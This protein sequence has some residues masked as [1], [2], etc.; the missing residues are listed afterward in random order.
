MNRLFTFCLL[1][2]FILCLTTPAWAAPDIAKPTNLIAYQESLVPEGQTVNSVLLIGKDGIIAGTVKDEVI[3]ITGSV[4]I[5][6]TA[7]VS[8]RVFVIGGDIKQE[9][10]AK[11]SKGVFNISTSSATVNSL[12]LGL[13]T[14]VGIEIIKLILSVCIVIASLIVVLIAPNVI[15]KTADNMRE[16]A[17]K[18]AV[19]GLLGLLS[20]GL[21][22][23]ALIIS[24]W[25]IILV[26]V[27]VVLLLIMI[28]I[29]FTGIGLVL[30]E[31]FRKGTNITAQ[32]KL[33]LTLIGS[34][35]LIAMLNLP[36]IGVL[37]GI[38]VNVLALGSSVQLLLQ[39][40]SKGK[41]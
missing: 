29:G 5:K 6:S 30:G 26:F 34:L 23:A 13:M 39:K 41:R 33:I 18:S 32:S 20:F 4:T 25:G 19:L 3:V 24:V 14:F 36:I 27:I 2:L 7:R 31:L 21:L 37:W 40:G 28:A 8:D 1:V 15:D 16:G 38:V 10:G 22:T 12:I 11:V 35:M 9:P 17:L